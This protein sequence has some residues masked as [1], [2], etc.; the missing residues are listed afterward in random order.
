MTEK[1]GQYEVNQE[2]E[3]DRGTMQDAWGGGA[4]GSLLE[5]EGDS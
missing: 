2:E 3:K 5:K 1:E 4:L